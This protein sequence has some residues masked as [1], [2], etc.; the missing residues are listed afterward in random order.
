MIYSHQFKCLLLYICLFSSENFM[1]Y[2]KIVFGNTVVIF[3]QLKFY[4]KNDLFSNENNTETYSFYS[5]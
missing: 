4:K 3:C 1:K 2:L 5:R